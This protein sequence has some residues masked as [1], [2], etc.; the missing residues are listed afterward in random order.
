MQSINQNKMG[1]NLAFS[2]SIP[3]DNALLPV[4]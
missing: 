1:A 2:P 3:V 4:L